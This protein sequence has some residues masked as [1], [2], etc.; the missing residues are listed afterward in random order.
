MRKAITPVAAFLT[1]LPCVLMCADLVHGREAVFPP[2]DGR[3]A[4]L[5]PHADQRPLI[6]ADFQ[7]PAWT[8]AAEVSSL[9]PSYASQS[10]VRPSPTKVLLL[11]D[12]SFLYVRFLCGG[13]PPRNVQFGRDADLYLGDVV[14]VFLSRFADVR[15]YFEIQVSPA[16]DVLDLRF[17]MPAAPEFQSD[18]VLTKNY[19]LHILQKDRSWNFAKL[20]TASRASGGLWVVD[21]AI[22][23]REIFRRSAQNE[24][25]PG[26][27]RANF[28]RYEW[29]GTR[30]KRS[31]VSSNWSVVRQGCPQISPGSL[32]WL[33]LVTPSKAPSRK[34]PID[35]KF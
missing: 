5:V 32:G 11:W 13:R 20:R 6:S 27:L 31:L 29:V 24:L 22:P 3:P 12:R 26:W 25:R 16:N 7:D 33:R 34:R 4:I 8:F 28:L 14:E 30:G 19:S 17:A 9:L 15:E 23:A 10:S 35:S 2:V 21:M 1:C 18:G